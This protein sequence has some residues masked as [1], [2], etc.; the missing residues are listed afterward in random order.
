[1]LMQEYDAAIIG[2]GP[3]GGFIASRL[4]GEKHNIVVFEKKKAIGIPM[5][6]AGLVTSR[7]FKDFDISKKGIVQNEIKGA[8]IHSPG[9]NV[10]SIGGDKIHALVIDRTEFDQRITQ[11]AKK[12]GANILLGTKIE[13]IIRKKNR[14]ELK[15]SDDIKYST[16]LLI[17][18]DGPFSIVRRTFKMPEP[19]EFLYGTGAELTNTNLDP[20]F[21]HIFVGDKIAPGFFAWIIPTNKEGDNARIGLCT[22]KNSFFSSKY[23]LDKLFKNKETSSFI[24]D[25][26]LKQKTGGAIPL[27]FVKKNT[28]DNVMLVGDA[29]AHVKPTSGG[30]IFPGLYCAKLCSDVALETIKLNDFSASALKKYQKLCLNHVGK[31]LIKGH[32][33]RHISKKLS[34]KQ[35]DKYILKFSNPRVI[36]VIN[37]YGDIDYPSKLVKP[38]I[39]K[40]PYLLK[41]LPNLL[42]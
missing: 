2:A 11:E 1:M 21:V 14:L 35:I 23:Y 17:G 31:E 25:A 3:I 39:R 29:A 19:K 16:N 42:K 15:T 24:K 36:E 28:I 12:R 37:K 5:N 8:H 18:A 26:K 6:C 40:T 33:F 32:Y 4:A 27:G 38:L 41:V 7:V 34:D 10:L 9:G 20:D 13:K 22:N 30:G